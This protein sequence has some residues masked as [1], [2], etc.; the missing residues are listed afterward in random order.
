M[1]GGGPGRRYWSGA[2]VETSSRR[3]R[4]GFPPMEA[5]LGFLEPYRRRR[6]AVGSAASWGQR[7]R[8]EPPARSIA[9]SYGVLPR[10]PNCAVRYSSSSARLRA[11]PSGA[12]ERIVTL[13]SPTCHS[14]SRGTPS[15][16]ITRTRTG[17]LRTGRGCFGVS[18][19]DLIQVRIVSAPDQIAALDT[20][21]FDGIVA[22]TDFE[23]ALARRRPG[24]SGLPLRAPRDCASPLRR[25]LRRRPASRE[26][27]CAIARDR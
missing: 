9:S 17:C 27:A 16:A 14:V 15:L 8:P 25:K 23:L 18:P 26:Q 19:G 5:A 11:S 20:G 2:G 6:D 7:E 12:S 3:G 22:E 13:V 4:H 1:E 10:R 21:G 24:K